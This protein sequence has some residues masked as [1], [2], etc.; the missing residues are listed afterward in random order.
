MK[1]TEDTVNKLL[2]VEDSSEAAPKLWEIL[3][4]KKKRENLFREFLNVSKDVTYDWFQEYFEDSQA[5]RKRD[6]Q[7][8]TPN[9]VSNILM[10]L[11][12]DDGKYFEPTCGTGGIL[13]KRW[14]KDR[15]ADGFFEYKPSNH[16]YHVEDKSNTAMPFLLFNCIIRGMNVI[17]FWGDSLSRE[18]KDIFF[19]QNTKDCDIAFSDL[20]VMPRSN[21]V[22]HE[23]NVSSW[24]GKH[25]EH[26][27]SE[28]KEKSKWVIQ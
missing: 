11:V 4:D 7:D 2:G 15:K 1:F 6:K 12:D 22:M 19:I 16:F 9:S 5:N 27:E 23:F 3:F 24:K 14:D 13:I 28:L 10:K 17:V 25:I 20:N 8:F 26:V 18:C 21:E